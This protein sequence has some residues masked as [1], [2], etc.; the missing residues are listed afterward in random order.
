MFY[1]SNQGAL[2]RLGS[3]HKI[4]DR[5]NTK[6]ESVMVRN[7]ELLSDERAAVNLLDSEGLLHYLDK[8][9]FRG[10][11]DVVIVCC[12]DGRHFL[13]GILNPFMEMYDE[14]QQFRIHPITKHGGTLVLDERS[15]LVRSGHTTGLDL[16]LE[17][18]DAMAM[19]YKALC[20]INH[21]PC[22]MGRKFNIPP[23]WIV[24]SLIAAKRRIK[25]HVREITVACFLQVADGENRRIARIPFDDYVAWRKE[26]VKDA[27]P[28]MQRMISSLA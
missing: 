16:V 11:E 18:S 28:S 26:S 4:Y 17:V 13:R 2:L 12:P 1:S 15:S 25:L 9:H 6:E 22:G 8:E 23:L 5:K 14:N 19:G 21:F 10:K 20:L 27:S 3:K 24:D 7:M